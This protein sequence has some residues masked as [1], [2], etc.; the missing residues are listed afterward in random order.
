M[1]KTISESGIMGNDIMDLAKGICTSLVISIVVKL[2]TWVSE[3]FK[4]SR[5]R[6]IVEEKEP[7][8]HL[9]EKMNF[10][11]MQFLRNVTYPFV[12]IVFN[13]YMSYFALGIEGIEQSNLAVFV[14]AVIIYI[15]YFYIK[16]V[17]IDYRGREIGYS[18][19]TIL[20]LL[21]GLF[22]EIIL[23]QAI[24]AEGTVIHIFV[25]A[26]VTGV[27]IVT[28]EILLAKIGLYKQLECRGYK[29]FEI[30]RIVVICIEAIVYA[31]S[32]IN[33]D[34]SILELMD[35][36][37]ITSVLIILACELIIW[38]HGQLKELEKKIFLKDGTIKTTFCGI[39]EGKN[40]TIEWEESSY[41]INIK[42]NQVVKITY[43]AHFNPTK[44]K[45]RDVMLSDGT[46][47]SG[48]RYRAKTNWCGLCRRSEGGLEIELYPE[49]MISAKK[50]EK[51]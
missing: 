4:D 35:Y 22:L 6:W 34:I 2:I 1:F 40:D 50:D 5:N 23:V 38:H 13:I 10:M 28:N 7:N 14:L 39:K 3:R 29:V 17:E 37:C 19:L 30:L 45:T 43:F 32:I 48:Y 36:V 51:V 26:F 47:V 11:M 18:G 15:V 24:D 8:Y 49:S 41:K 12:L 33:S 27:Q 25:C 20:N 16:G 44:V 9:D 42:R 46:I 21:C 31:A